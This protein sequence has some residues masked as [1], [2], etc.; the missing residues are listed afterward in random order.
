MKVLVST[1]SFGKHDKEPIRLLESSGFEVVLNPHG[2]R[3]GP[4][5]IVELG[6]DCTGIIAGTEPMTMAVLKQLPLLKAISRVGVGLENIDVEAAKRLGIKVKGTTDAPTQ[7]VAELT[8]GLIL[9]VIR[10]I[11]SMDRGIRSGT[12]NK[13]MGWLLFGKT[14]GIVG[15]GRIGRRVAEL[16]RPFNVKILASEPKP[17]KKWVRRNRVCLTSLDELLRGSD[18]VTLHIPYTKQNRNLINAEKL[19]IMKRGAILINT[20][21]G[22]L[23]DEGALYQALKKGDLGGA[24]LDV[25][26]TEPYD[27]PLKELD[28]VVLT[29]HIGSY[30]LETRVRMETDAVKNLIKMLKERRE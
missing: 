22:G 1:T 15:I 3:L 21:R 7:A 16:L 18:V 10:K 25:M 23:V 24:G 30:A 17:G 11:N 19:K 20:S 12:W 4:D 8:L 13:E 6:K 27:G 26:K 2:R 9:N 14:V 28:N 29:P 5:E